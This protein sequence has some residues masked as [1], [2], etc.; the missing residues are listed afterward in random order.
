MRALA[1]RPG[2]W[3]LSR[4]RAVRFVLMRAF[5]VRSHVQFEVSHPRGMCQSSARNAYEGR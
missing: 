1:E 3:R 5:R 4:Q 2:S